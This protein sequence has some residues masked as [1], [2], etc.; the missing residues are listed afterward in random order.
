MSLCCRYFHRFCGQKVKMLE[1]GVQ[2]RTP[3]MMP[4][5]LHHLVTTTCK[6]GC[7][8]EFM[9]AYHPVVDTLWLTGLQSGGSIRMWQHYFGKD[10]LTHIGVDIDM[11][12]Q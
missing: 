3:G 8:A 5:A 9:T 12:A 11:Y 10:E 6:A 7:S 1:I 4:H 2:V